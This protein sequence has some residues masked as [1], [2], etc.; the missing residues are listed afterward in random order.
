[1]INVGIDTGDN[2]VI[3]KQNT[4]NF[5]DIVVALA[6]CQNTLKTYAYGEELQR[7]MLQ[8][9]NDEYEPIYPDELYIQ[10]VAINV[11]KKL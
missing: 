3:K 7:V 5:G 10:G 2:V 6:D 4:A 11:I 9:E 1:M 8:L